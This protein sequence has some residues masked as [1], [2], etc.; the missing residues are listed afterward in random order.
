MKVG[1][2]GYGSIGQFLY[3]AAKSRN[4]IEVLWVWNR[5]KE[6]LNELQKDEILDNI[7][8]IPNK[9]KV[10][11]I[12]EVAHPSITVNYGEFLL[13]QA[14]YF[15]GSP[16]CFADQAVED[17]IRNALKNKNPNKH[18]VYVPAGALW[19]S[20]DIFK[21][22]ALGTLKKLSVTMKKHPTSLKLN[23][24]LSDKLEEVLKNKPEGEVVLY[25]GGVRG[26]CPLAPNNVNTMAAAALVGF[27]LGFDDVQARLVCDFSL[28]GHVI[29]IDA[30][31]APNP[32]GECFR[33]FT[34]RYNP[35]A[36]GAVTGQATYDS[37]LSSVLL[38]HSKSPDAIH[39]C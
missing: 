34:E 6:A 13:E 32:N 23:G 20:Q 25:E 15:V 3:N 16:T 33:V 17:K 19:G 4:D 8:D 22:A 37:F 38:A 35:A 9:A 7:E 5:S 28:T 30:S 14:N 27:N 10:D 24:E 29:T 12:I 39:L 21:M 2:L 18:A 36:A 31:G 11:L 1:I 26:L